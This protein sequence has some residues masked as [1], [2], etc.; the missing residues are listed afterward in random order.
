MSRG[1]TDAD[2]FAKK[3]IVSC[4]FYSSKKS[5]S[6]DQAV[7]IALEMF[8]PLLISIEEIGV[9]EYLPARLLCSFRL[10]AD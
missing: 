3:G 8:L 2:S 4:L 10:T 6:K 1:R 9:I 7:A 5:K